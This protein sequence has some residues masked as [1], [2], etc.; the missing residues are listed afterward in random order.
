MLRGRGAGRGDDRAGAP[1]TRPVS[2]SISVP[3]RRPYTCERF[4][5]VSTSA[6]GARRVD[7]TGVQQHHVVGDGCRVVEVV[8]HDTQGGAVVV[9]EL[10]HQVERLHLVAQ[11]EVVGRLVE[12]QHARLLR[13]RGRQPHALQ[14]A[15]RELVD[16][17]RGHRAEPRSVRAPAR[18]RR[19]RRR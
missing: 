4:S 3:I 17:A 16:G 1:R 12:E 7:S 13:Q 11:V 9:G 19:G 14:F 2:S 6:G 5:P 10:A 15:A 18:R 8:Q